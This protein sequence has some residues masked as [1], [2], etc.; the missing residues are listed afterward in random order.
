MKKH[1]F[2]ILAA[3]SVVLPMYS[4]DEG[5]RTIRLIQDDAQEKMATKLYT[6]KNLKAS[7][8]YN[9][10]QQAVLRYSANSSVRSLNYKPQPTLIVTTPQ[11]FIPY[12]DQIISILDRGTQKNDFGSSVAGTG[13]KWRV[14]TPNYRHVADFDPIAD[15]MLSGGGEL[16]NQNGSYWLK[17]DSGDIDYALEWMNYFDRP[18]PQASLT[19]R[20]YTVRESTLRDIGVDYLAWKNG[21]GMNLVDLAYDAGRIAWDKVFNTAASIGSA[22]SWSYGGAFTAPAFDF[23]FIRLLQ[24]SGDA[25]VVAESSVTVVNNQSGATISLAPSY[26]NQTKDQNFASHVETADFLSDMNISVTN[27]R[28]CFMPAKDEINEYGWI[29]SDKAFYDKNKG[30]VVFGYTVQSNDPTEANNNGLLIGNQFTNS[31]WLKCIECG[32][33]QVLAHNI[34]ENDIEQT[35]GVP[36]LCQ[37]PILKYIFGT[38]TTIKDK[39]HC[40]VTVEA[41]LVYP[42]SGKKN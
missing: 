8:I 18:L 42:N 12:V 10:V 2:A 1:L 31:N 28:I 20:Y 25:K 13:V 24:Q 35:T 9:Y 38:T 16:Y 27:P 15:I 34:R 22:M 3:A 7:D 29:P 37:L 5:T 33:E 36:F 23:S 40:I 4:A 11:E 19:F 30:S 14:W 6:L 41:N 32:K 17:D 39:T 26:L 21:P